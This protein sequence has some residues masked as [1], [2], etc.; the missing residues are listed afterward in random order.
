MSDMLASDHFAPDL[1]DTPY[2]SVAWYDRLHAIVGYW[3]E[4]REIPDDLRANPVDRTAA[5]Q[6]LSTEARFLDQERLEEWLTLSRTTVSWELNDRRRL[7]ERVERLATERAYSQAPSTRTM[8]LYS[9]LE[10]LSFTPNV[11]HVICRIFI[12]T[13]LAGKLSPRAGWNGYILRK[14]DD[15]WRI[16]LKRIGLFDADYP[17][18]NNSFTL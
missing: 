9:N 16:A 2:F 13:S 14:V 18:D 12:Q 7:E 17:Q 15:E 6:L 5:E 11:M 4:L 1:A 10:V 8:H 3:L